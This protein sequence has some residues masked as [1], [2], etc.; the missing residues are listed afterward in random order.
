MER[1]HAR[2]W[3]SDNVDRSLWL[4]VPKWGRDTGRKAMQ[5]EQMPWSEVMRRCMMCPEDQW[6]KQELG[7]GKEI[8]R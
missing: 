8:C 3:G 7:Y 6:D 4:G 1:V 2:A 5:C